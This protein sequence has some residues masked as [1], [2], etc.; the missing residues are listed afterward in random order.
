MLDEPIVREKAREAIRAGELPTRLPDRTWGG[1][2]I[3]EPC[4]IC[5][6]RIKRD[7]LEFEIQFAHDG[8]RPELER[9][10]VHVRCFAAWEFERTKAEGW[11]I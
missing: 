2:G 5:G 9:F 1:P 8:A 6:E 3:G 10:H 11:S 4:T 7:Q